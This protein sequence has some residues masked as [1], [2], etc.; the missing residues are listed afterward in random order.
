MFW[1]KKLTKLGQIQTK[2]LFLQIIMFLGEKIEKIG[3]ESKKIF[4][5]IIC[6]DQMFDQTI[7][8]RFDQVS[9]RSSVVSIKSGSINSRV[10]K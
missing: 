2:N 10:M 6:F 9:F 3:A 7:K 4:S 5:F 1:E 8:C